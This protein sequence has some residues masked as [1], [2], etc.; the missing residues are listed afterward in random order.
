MPLLPTSTAE[1]R[2]V[3]VRR[4]RRGA[5]RR[6]R[7]LLLRTLRFVACVCG[8]LIALLT[9]RAGAD[10]SDAR[11]FEQLRARKLFNLA[12]SLCRRRLQEEGLAPADRMQYSIELARSFAAHAR[13]QAEAAERVELWNAAHATL[14]AARES[15]TEAEQRIELAVQEAIVSCDQAEFDG[16]LSELNPYHK[17]QRADVATLRERVLREL[18]QLE[19]VLQDALARPAGTKPL[20]LARYRALQKGVLYQAGE[21][22]VT[23]GRAFDRA[24]PERGA[25]F[26]QAEQKLKRVA[27]TTTDDRIVWLSQVSLARLM[28]LKL[29]VDRANSMLTAIERDEPP[30]DILDE[31]I[32]ERVELFAATKRLPDS[33]DLL[34][35]Y[36]QKQSQFSARLAFLAA[37]TWLDLS[38]LA[39]SKRQMELAAELKNEAQRTIEREPSLAEGYWAHRARLYWDQFEEAER[40]GE[41]MAA[42]LQ[43]ARGLYAAGEFE[44]ALAAFQRAFDAAVE[45][46]ASEL[47]FEIGLTLARLQLEQRHVDD[48]L[49]LLD[50]MLTLHA[51][52]QRIA[53]LDLLRTICL[54]RRFQTNPTK[55]LREGY[56]A[57]LA[58][59]VE[60]Y[61]SSPTAADAA[62][63]AAQLKEKLAQFEAAL[64]FYARIPA[65]H[66]RETDALAAAARCYRKLVEI[67][68]SQPDSKTQRDWSQEALLKLTPFAEQLIEEAELFETHIEFLSQTA[69]IAV[70]SVELP[71]E[72]PKW[73]KR[74]RQWVDATADQ[75]A[76]MKTITEARTTALRLHVLLLTRQRSGIESQ[77]C[78]A[79]LKTIPTTTRIE[80]LKSLDRA[81]SHLPLTNRSALATIAIGALEHAALDSPPPSRVTRIEIERML[82]TA[83]G[84]IGDAANAKAAQQRMERLK[85]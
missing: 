10:E 31:V 73:I 79:E 8:L 81:I 68:R 56:E 71:R 52:H 14:K 77:R 44:D 51:E 17:R 66:A 57:A 20:T 82:A 43:E 42:L 26:L 61:A 32:A 3:A 83:Y 16:L 35:T 75:E 59:H 27:S 74:I 41:R 23:E 69:C 46:A 39:E 40:Y 48:A 25:A 18:A 63:M 76:D 78:V 55:A 64:G 11:Y 30:T 19:T 6:L 70:T 22:L 85:P 2:D 33:A 38:R 49:S 47:S 45:N 15:V 13:Q 1:L 36:R 37:R 4:A 53:E 7:R 12:E 9:T 62:W 65:Q 80:L 5:D 50:R 84:T 29:D 67:S 72:T 34:R 58:Q 21:L 28:R 60:R 24:S 54:G